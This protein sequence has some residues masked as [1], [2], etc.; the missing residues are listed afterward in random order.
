MSASEKANFAAVDYVVFCA[1]LILSLSIGLYQWW[2]SRGLDSKDFLMGGGK[3]SP[4]PVAISLFAGM[5]S[6]VSILGNPA[7][8]YYYGSQLWMNC[9]GTII[10]TIMASVLIV[11]VIY[12]LNLVSLYEFLGLRWKSN[13]VRKLAIFLQLIN[14]FTFLGIAL[15]APSLALSSVTP[16]PAEVSV[17]VLGIV[18]TLYASLGGAKAV[19]YTDTVQA[20]IMLAGIIAVI[21]QGCSQ[22]GGGTN[23][24]KI[25]EEN[26]R[27]EFF[28]MSTDPLERHTLMSTLI[29]GVYFAFNCYGVGQAQFQR[30]ASVSTIKQSYM[31][32]AASCAILVAVWSLINY[33]GLV[34]FSV[35][36]D[37]DPLTAGYIEKIDQITVYFVI[38]KLGYLSGI[39]GLFVA[40]IYSGVLSTVSS[41]LNAMAA[42]IWKDL[43]SGLDRFSKF[44]PQQEKTTAIIISSVSGIISTGMGILAG[45]MGG[46]FEITYALGGAITGPISGLF[47]MAVTCPWVKS[48]SACTGLLLSITLTL[49]MVTGNFLYAP[50]TPMLP[51][52]TDGC[53]RENMTTTPLLTESTTPF[54]VSS[55]DSGEDPGSDVFPLYLVT[56]CLYGAT[57]TLATFV[58]SNLATL[59]FGPMA[60]EKV[61]ENTVQ[62]PSMQFY[63]WVQ[64]LGGNPSSGRGRLSSDKSCRDNLNSCHSSPTTNKKA[65]EAG[66][67]EAY[68]NP[69]FET[70]NHL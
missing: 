50:P 15:Y 7:E 23:S 31:V 60:I 10:G 28:N 46:I 58:F 69:A 26:G 12:P 55:T 16:I 20:F 8:M 17:V 11:P 29:L 49:W 6:A 42:V 30:W 40:A 44:T 56:Y 37:C 21:I 61:P 14:Y 13:L 52:S 5:V 48:Q 47:L 67:A 9:L 43:L 65:F 36:S 32:L 57:G 2:K 19:V 68:V 25:D 41:I 62:K 70:E 33:S 51:L 63:R 1:S 34:I 3:M 24:W 27:I 4:I 22:V 64:S 45:S 38:D 54:L 18:C 39:P 59:V 66:S 35:Y 53:P